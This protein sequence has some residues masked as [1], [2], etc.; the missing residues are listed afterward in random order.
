MFLSTVVAAMLFTCFRLNYVVFKKKINPFE[1]VNGK[2]NYKEALDSKTGK[3][4][5]SWQRNHTLFDSCRTTM[6]GGKVIDK[7]KHTSHHFVELMHKR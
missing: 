2:N 3:L 6:R 7:L 5:S 1:A 4:E